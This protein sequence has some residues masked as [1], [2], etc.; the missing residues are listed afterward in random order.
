[1]S[2]AATVANLGLAATTGAAAAAAGAAVLPPDPSIWAVTVMGIPLGVLG[3]SLAGSSAR[4]LRDGAADDR[5]LPKRA[6][7]TLIDGF[8]GGWVAIFLLSFTY[9]RTYFSGVE[10]VILGALAG[11][12]TEYLRTN[13]PRWAEQA[14]STALALFSRKRAPGDNPP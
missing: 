12:L 6:V 5:R 1:V 4:T 13:A 9:T 2:L 14:W 3:A 10:P 11:L 8:I 7:D